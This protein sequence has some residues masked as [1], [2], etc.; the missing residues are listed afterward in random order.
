MVVS[1]NE[2]FFDRSGSSKSLS[3]PEDMRIF[4]FLR[5]QAD[6]VLVGASTA[7]SDKYG[8]VKIR[9][10]FRE[11][12]RH[13]SPVM[14]V[15]SRSLNFWSEA[16]LFS[17]PENKPT[18]F[19]LPSDDPEWNERR[20]VLGDIANVVVLECPPEATIQSAVHYLASLEMTHILCEGGPQILTEALDANLVNDVCMT[21][22]PIDGK[23]SGHEH[24]YERLMAYPVQYEIVT[25][26]FTF[27]R[28]IAEPANQ[29][30]A[31]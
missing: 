3:G 13:E 30:N 9:D 11:Y 29:E 16:R 26:A 1:S 8:P 10:E 12:A 20:K 25:E 6:A 15:V 21:H 17:D 5:S 28:G 7:R 23:P 24:L 27:T 19:T 22:S 14:T 4:N 18:I 2:S 31:R